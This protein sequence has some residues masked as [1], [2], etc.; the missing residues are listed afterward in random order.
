MCY[1]FRPHSETIIFSI[2]PVNPVFCSLCVYT[3]INGNVLSFK[4]TIWPKKDK[5]TQDICLFQFCTKCSSQVRDAYS[6]QFSISQTFDPDS[7][8]LYNFV[9]NYIL[10]FVSHEVYDKLVAIGFIS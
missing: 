5:L 4:G 9:E 3:G 7:D 6:F 10:S 1:G 8:H 2:M